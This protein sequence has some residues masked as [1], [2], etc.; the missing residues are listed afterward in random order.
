[1]VRLRRAQRPRL[2]ASDRSRL[3]TIAL[4]RLESR[5]LL[6]ATGAR[7][8]GTVFNDVN[9]TGRQGHGD[10]GLAGWTVFVESND[11]GAVDNDDVGQFD[12]DESIAVT[13][14]RG[15]WSI[16]G[17]SAGTY[18]I[19]EV[20]QAGWRQ[21]SPAAFVV[22]LGSHSRLA[23][24]NFANTQTAA[25]SGTV[26]LDSN[27]NGVQDPGEPGMRGCKVFADVH[28][29]GKLDR[30]E[31][32][33]VSD[34]HGN[35]TLRAVPA[36]Q[37]IIREIPKHGYTIT[38]PAAGAFALT[39]AA[40][41]VSA[42]NNFAN[43]KGAAHAPPPNPNPGGN[44]PPPSGNGFIITSTRSVWQFDSSKDVITFYARDPGTGSLAG[45]S[46]LI[47]EETTLSSAGGLLIRTY[48]D[49]G[50]GKNDDADFAGKS[51]SPKAS[52][53]NLGPTTFVASTSPTATD[54][55][56]HDFQLVSQFEVS[57]AVLAGV[58]ATAGRG[59]VIAVAVVPH[60]SVVN[61]SGQLSA[62]QGP[63]LSFSASA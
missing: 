55:S 8:S 24:R 42:G 30:G 62:D 37:V 41:Q 59:A 57:G 13:D 61:I 35:Y 14:A 63:I 26:F 40:A 7:I 2:L 18:S 56:Y 12:H 22:H 10:T 6:S 32:S 58:S 16:S 49:E 45:S 9:A 23:N 27:G 52:Y 19:R 50:S 28:G 53:I 17:L 54:N 34:A 21:T 44:P 11:L 4:E 47:A 20:L 60:G 48:D 5:V 1:M 31:P 29:N 36:G 3:P 25:V 46:R 39:L 38:A 15:N 51:A 43:T 33:A